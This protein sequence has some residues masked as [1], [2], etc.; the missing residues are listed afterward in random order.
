M[1][2]GKE[3]HEGK[4]S[5]SSF[6]E[7]RSGTNSNLPKETT[8]M[9]KMPIRVSPPNNSYLIHFVALLI[10]EMNRHLEAVQ[11]R[12]GSDRYFTRVEAQTGA[13]FYRWPSIDWVGAV[14][15]RK[16]FHVIKCIRPGSVHEPLCIGRVFFE[17]VVR[18]SYPP[19]LYREFF[20]VIFYICPIK[21][22]EFQRI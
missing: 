9:T 6:P 17:F 10:V 20:S 13:E 18:H 14:N 3:H 8:R 5:M 7:K 16:S 4:T 2:C 1:I 11:D 22:L 12:T 15:E 21:Y 19:H